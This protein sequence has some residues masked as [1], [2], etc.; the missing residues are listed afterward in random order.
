M[1]SALRAA[2]Y[3]YIRYQG[4]WDTD[5]LYDLQADPREQHNLIHDTFHAD[6]VKKMNRQLFEVLEQTGGLNIPLLPDRGGVNNKRR[7]GGAKPG[8]FPS[9]IMQKDDQ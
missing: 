6:T 3:K 5:E 1:K 4:I 7:A 8:E 2:R 9:E